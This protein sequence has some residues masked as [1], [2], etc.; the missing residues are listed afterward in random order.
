MLTSM[1]DKYR[2]KN[3]LPRRH[4]YERASLF[5]SFIDTACLV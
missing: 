2:I 5:N 4:V 3:D 1:F